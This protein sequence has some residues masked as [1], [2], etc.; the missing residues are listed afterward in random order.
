MST[1]PGDISSR[2]NELMDVYRVRCL[3]FLRQDYYP[4]TV[5]DALRALKYIQR[6]GD[7]EAFSKA[8]ELARCLSP[9]SNN[10]FAA[11]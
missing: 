3:W 2:V 5:E 7:R 11:S 10:S 1:L 6:Y 8:G 9:N 4:E